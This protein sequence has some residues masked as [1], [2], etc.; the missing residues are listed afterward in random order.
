MRIIQVNSQFNG[1]GVDTQTLEL[2]AG[3]I[4][5]GHE[6]LLAINP[7]ARWAP[8]AAAIP[9]LRI[10]V[11]EGGKLAFGLRLRRLA[12]QF[13]ARIMH[14]HHG[15]DYWTTG[16]GARLAANRPQAV[17]TR[18]LMTKLSSTSARYLLRLG[19]ITAVSKAV[20]D[21]LAGEL[22]GNLS[23]L[24]LIYAGIDT[25]RYKPDL[26][27]RAIERG[28]LGWNES[29]IVYA[30]VGA[31]ALPDGKG[32]REFVEAGARLIREQ[33]EVRMLIVGDGTLVPVLRQR[34][35]Q[36]EMENSIRLMPFTEQ[37]E[38]VYAA[39]DVL[40]HPAV[41]TEALGLVIWEA[42]AAAKPI[43]AS[44][45]HGI[46]ETFLAPDHGRLVSPR[47][48]DDLYEAMKIF[49]SDRGLRERSGGAAREH[50][51][52]QQ[53]TRGGQAKRFGDFYQSIQPH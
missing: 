19:H 37:V 34:I 16:L 8:R 51:L 10:E 26:A 31:I 3:L 5:L 36:L 1:G 53:F 13:Q 28:R 2:C 23:K 52:V 27:T 30:V 35:A 32:Q 18:H 17:L 49:A 20:Y 43:I 50:I 21:N 25:E 11:V 29:K 14:A 7:N 38:C 24:H 33:P 9:G 45:L 12:E 48:V 42:M 6:V 44:R 22:A 41:S 15:R 39:I 4:E 46:P 40:V 47:S